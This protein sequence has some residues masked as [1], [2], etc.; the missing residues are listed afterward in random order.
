MC[1]GS[2]YTVFYLK[3]NKPNI[4]PPSKVNDLNP[5]NTINTLLMKLFNFSYN[6]NKN[7][8]DL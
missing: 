7:K 1:D 4:V 3:E 6:S 5:N 2:E 8:W